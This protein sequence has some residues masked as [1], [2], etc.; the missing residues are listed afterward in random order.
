MI[1]G[2]RS[3]R[4]T[5]S[6]APANQAST[7]RYLAGRVTS[8]QLC[9]DLP[10]GLS[11]GSSI[12][13]ERRR[14]QCDLPMIPASRWRGWP[15][16]SSTCCRPTAA[17]VSGCPRSPLRRAWPWL[18]HSAGAWQLAAFRVSEGLGAQL[19][20]FAF[21]LGNLAVSALTSAE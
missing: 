8:G 11:L 20:R 13:R 19:S 5:C 12:D 17:N 21:D 10:A 9:P 7:R 16:R 14:R 1:P 2:N 6:I 15:L 4:K 18:R 3:P